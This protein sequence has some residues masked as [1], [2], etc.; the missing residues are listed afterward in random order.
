MKRFLFLTLALALLISSAYA[1]E[2]EEPAPAVA[3][4]VS[5]TLDEPA[6][7]E[8]PSTL[9]EGDLVQL[10]V[11]LK[12]LFGEYQPRTQTVTKVLEDGSSISYQEY[13]PGVAGMDIEW[14]AAVGLFALFLFCVMKLVGGVFKL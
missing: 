12:D 7:G 3:P 1:A 9:S 5:Y 10:S 6:G 4:Y 8:P 13:V 2:P 11:L 14:L